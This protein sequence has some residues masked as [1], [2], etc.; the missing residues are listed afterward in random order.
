[1]LTHLHMGRLNP[2]FNHIH[3]FFFPINSLVLSSW[4]VTF[5]IVFSFLCIFTQSY[6]FFYRF[7]TMLSSGW[8]QNHRYSFS[9]LCFRFHQVNL[10]PWQANNV[11]IF[12]LAF[13]LA[14]LVWL[15]STYKICSVTYISTCVQGCI[16]RTYTRFVLALCAS[17][18]CMCVCMHIALFKHK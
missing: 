4:D 10:F 5:S 9:S 7:L 3:L 15:D 1:M 13:F 6:C 8:G 12:P 16:Y 2:L 11:Y 14:L 17:T 18:C